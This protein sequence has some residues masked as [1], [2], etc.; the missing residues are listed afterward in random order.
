M[1]RRKFLKFLGL[2]GAVAVIPVLSKVE[3]SPDAVL[4]QH[5]MTV[6]D[7]LCIGSPTGGTKGVLRSGVA[8]KEIWSQKLLDDKE[9]EFKRTAQNGITVNVKTKED[10]KFVF[11]DARPCL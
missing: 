3:G 4:S 10:G 1:N 2:G 11:N 9:I 7:K 6:S 8:P 5:V